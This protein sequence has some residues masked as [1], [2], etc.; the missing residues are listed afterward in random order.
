MARKRYNRKK[1]SSK[2][3]GALAQ[4]AGKIAEN[5]VKESLK[6]WHRM[7]RILYI[8]TG[9][10]IIVQNGDVKI[11][12]K[13]PPDWI[14]AFSFPLHFFNRFFG[15]EGEGASTRVAVMG[16]TD[17]KHISHAK[18]TALLPRTHQFKDMYNMV[19]KGGWGGYIVNWVYNGDENNWLYIPAR[20]CSIVIT[21]HNKEHDEMVRIYRNGG[22]KVSLIPDSPDFWL[23]VVMTDYFDFLGAELNPMYSGEIIG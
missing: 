12:G 5:K 16:M 20:N 13:A 10:P 2:N 6:L 8:N 11:I 7:N 15:V 21:P 4:K 18:E 9:P 3:K 23:N 17:T 14:I 22:K 19:E 1:G